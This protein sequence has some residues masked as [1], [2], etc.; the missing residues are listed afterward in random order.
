[1]QT[2]LVG[3]LAQHH[4]P[5]GQFAV[6]QKAFLPLGNGRAHAQDGV[7][8]LLDVFDEPT[9]LLQALLQTLVALALARR[10]QRVGIN[11]MHTQARH[12]VRVECHAKLGVALAVGACAGDQ[13]IG[14]HRIALHIDKTPPGLGLQA[15]NQRNGQLDGGLA[16]IDRQHQALDVAARQQL[17]RLGTNAQGTVAHAGGLFGAG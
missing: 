6:L 16:V 2:Q 14:H 10:F 13:D 4:R 5:H 7:K 17:Q 15:C 9:R 11:V 1:M 8:P 3:D 12:H